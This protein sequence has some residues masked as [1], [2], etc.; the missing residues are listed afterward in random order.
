MCSYLTKNH[1][2]YILLRTADINVALTQG[3]ICQNNKKG[4]TYNTPLPKIHPH[5]KS[6]L[7]GIKLSLDNK[8]SLGSSQKLQTTQL[9]IFLQYLR[10]I[11]L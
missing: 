8:L 5:R 4:H 1:L 6:G 9:Y 11:L 2:E 10:N 7:N 3:R